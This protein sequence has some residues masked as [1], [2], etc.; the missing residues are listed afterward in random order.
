MPKKLLWEKLFER[1]F[2]YRAGMFNFMF[3]NNNAKSNKS[4]KKN[5]TNCDRSDHK[6]EVILFKYS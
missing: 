6:K 5:C 3:L 2:K 1:E 4:D